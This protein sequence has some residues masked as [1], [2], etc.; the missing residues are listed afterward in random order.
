MRRRLPLLQ[1]LAACAVLAACADSEAP[2]AVPTDDG[3]AYNVVDPVK[4]PITDDTEPA[5]GEWIQSMQ[6][7]QTV[8]Q[9]G[10]ANTEPLFSI[11]C[12]SRGGI[13]LNRHGSVASDR[14]EMMTIAMGA[15]TRN[16]AVNP[17]QGPLPKLR[18]AVPA[19]DELLTQLR[20]VQQPIRIS[21]GDGPPL[22]LPASPAI[23]EFIEDC[24]NPRAASRTATPAAP[25]APPEDVNSVVANVTR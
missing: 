9:F 17:A 3:G 2:E 18:A 20:Q 16:L 1:A 6:D 8:L 23:G 5:I 21:M 15:E 11:G 12:D 14:G 4:A 19:Q 13:L 7:E 24:S 22:V 10:P 25:T